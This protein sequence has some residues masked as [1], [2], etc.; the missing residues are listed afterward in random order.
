MTEQTSM[1]SRRSS[2]APT[3][4]VVVHDVQR[5][6]SAVVS[7]TLTR[8][9]GTKLPE[10][11]PGAHVEVTLP[12]GTVRQYSLCSSRDDL[13]S[14][15]IG[16][17]RVDPAA[18]GKG[19]SAE[20]HDAISA[21]D[22]LEISWPRNH[23]RFEPA[24]HNLFIAGG[25]GITPLIPMIWEAQRT[26]AS[27]ELHYTGRS[28]RTM[29]FI[30]H[31]PSIDDDRIH[32][33]PR[34]ELGQRM[35]LGAILTEPEPDLHVYACG[36]SAMLNEILDRTTEWPRGS[37]HF[38]QFERLTKPDTSQPE[39]GG[40][41]EIEVASTGRTVTVPAG[42]SILNALRDDDIDPPSSCEEGW[43]GVCETGLL[44][45]QPDHRDD[46]LTP[47]E[48]AAGDRVMICVSRCSGTKMVLDL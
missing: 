33:Y 16:V 42:I 1:A 29:A 32:L 25:I 44:D 15:R 36:P 3:L 17:L 40:E 27:W 12:S 24:D 47:E 13:H 19:G 4:P 41:F 8:H 22:S 34:E 6:A 7:I 43:C 37:V 14:Y 2:T 30:D 39:V 21:G 38:E 26:A 31:L 18:G 23:F 48:R 11:E 28:R 45:G 5:C 35:N 20:L 46:F 10:W 9:Q